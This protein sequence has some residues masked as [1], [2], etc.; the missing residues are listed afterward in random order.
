MAETEYQHVP[1]T[2]SEMLNLLNDLTTP[3]E[4]NIHRDIVGSLF[5]LVLR[6]M[7][8]A[9]YTDVQVEMAKGR[10][11]DLA[12]RLDASDHKL[13]SATTQLA[14]TDQDVVATNTRIDQILTTPVDGVSAEE[15]IDGR[16]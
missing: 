11:K 16:D 9:G 6:C 4:G 10:F 13:T 3:L 5:E 14:E 2:E 15:V 7:V 1:K 8:D 12:S